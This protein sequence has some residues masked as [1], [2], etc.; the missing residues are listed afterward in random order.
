MGMAS[1]QEDI[2]QLDKA[3]KERDERIRELETMITPIATF[4][5]LSNMYMD[6]SMNKDKED[7]KEVCNILTKI[8][9]RLNLTVSTE[10]YNRIVSFDKDITMPKINV[11]GNNNGVVSDSIGI[12]L[13]PDWQQRLVS[14][15]LGNN[16]LNNGN[17]NQG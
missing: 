3:V 6:A 11:D 7:R 1:Y 2:E 13:S 5:R 16:L 4:E 10:L 14:G 17:S 8:Q 15:M 12:N 9:S